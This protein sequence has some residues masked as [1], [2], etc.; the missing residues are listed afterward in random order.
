MNRSD[1]P[2]AR[3][4]RHHGRVLVV[5]DEASVRDWLEIYLRRSGHQ[6]AVARDGE[7]ALR[8]VADEDFDLVLTDLKMPKVNGLDVLRAVKA[9]SPSTEVV[10]IT[11]FATTETAIEAMK[12]GAYDYFRKPFDNDELVA[13]VRRAI[14]SSRLACENERLSG[15]LAL[16]RTMVFSSE[17]VGRSEC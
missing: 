5:D 12:A 7:E 11:A 9:R 14:E 8:R 4:D 17:R 2:R 3:P 15:E 6:P 10:M 13:V 16:S 1:E